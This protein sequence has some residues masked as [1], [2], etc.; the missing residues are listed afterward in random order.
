M[1]ISIWER[2]VF[3]GKVVQRFLRL[4]VRL[5]QCHKLGTLRRIRFQVAQHG[6]RYRFFPGNGNPPRLH[7]HVAA[8]ENDADR[9]RLQMLQQG[10]CN[11]LSQAFLYLQASGKT[12]DQ[13]RQ[14]GQSDDMA[15][16]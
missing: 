5:G 14:F 4:L 3:A 16:R 11:L 15:A 1:S 2:S 9:L 8:A 10:L 6:R 7:A 12:I 13:S